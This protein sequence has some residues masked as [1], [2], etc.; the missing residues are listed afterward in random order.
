MRTA[1]VIGHQL[2]RAEAVR[3]VDGEDRDQQHHYHRHRDERH[4]CADDDHQTIVGN[5]R[6]QLNAA[7][8]RARRS[9]GPQITLAGGRISI[10]AAG[11]TKP[12]TV[13]LVRYD[14]RVNNV[15]IR[16]GEN[17]GRTLPHRNIVR[18]LQAVGTWS[19]KVASFPVPA[20]PSP[21]YRTA[22]LVQAGKGGPIVAA[23]RL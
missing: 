7:I 16:A 12:S 4:Q 19:G 5:D 13:W 14:P 10:G 9:G 8:A 23:A 15:P 6:Q 18:Q 1:R 22:V 3:Q 21:V 20:S 2:D 11:S 17:G